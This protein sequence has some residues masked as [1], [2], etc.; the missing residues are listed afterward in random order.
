MSTATP[1]TAIQAGDIVT[2]GRAPG[3]KARRGI[4]SYY[5]TWFFIPALVLYV[6]F[7]ALPTFSSFYFSLTRWSLFDSTFI[8]FDN[9]VQFFSDPQLYTSFIHTLI[10]A[11]HHLGREGDPRVLPRAAA[12]GSD[13]RPRLPAGGRLLPGAALDDRRRDHVEVAPRPVPRH[14]QRGARLLRPAAA[15]LVH[16]PEP[17]A[18]QHRRR[19]H[20][21]GHRHRDADLHGR[22]RRHPARVLRGGQDRRRRRLE[23]PAADHDPA[24]PRG[25]RDGHHPLAHRRPPVV[26]HHLG[27]HGWRPRLH[28]RR[29]RLGDL[30]AVPGRLLRPLD[31]GQR[32]AV[33][34]GH[35]DHGPALVLPQQKAGGTVIRE[36]R[37]AWIVGIIAILVSVV[38]FLVPFAFV[39]LQAAKTPAEASNLAFSW[40]TT[41]AVLPELRRHAELQ[42]RRRS[43]G[44]SSTAR[45]SRSARSC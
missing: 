9:Y 12:H 35:G 42:R 20:L 37:R 44:R 45:S 30:Q 31:R 34:P 17:G 4:K 14:G 11:R 23:D 19:R 26:R 13:H 33:P 39:L 2:E 24:D 27:H 28:Q 18:L 3:K 41:L 32:R 6:V 40:P 38:V 36:R 43:G 15:G 1:A 8:G 16:R 21:E 29:A 22:H 5:P 7:F 10:Y 25:D